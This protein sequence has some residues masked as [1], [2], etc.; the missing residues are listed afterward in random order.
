M[1]YEVFLH[2]LGH[3]Q[4]VDKRARTTRRRFANETRAQEFAEHWRGELWSQRLDHPDPV[5]GPPSP[6]EIKTLGDRWRGSN[7]DY[8]K[9]L[10][11]EK[12][13]RYEEA[14]FLL[15]RAVEWYSDHS[16]AL[17]RLGVLTYAGCGTTQSTIRSIELLGRAVRLDPALFDGNLFLGFALARENRETE[18]RRCF[19]RAILLDKHPPLAMSM[20][21]DTVADWGYFAEAKAL[22]QKAIKRDPKC[23]LAIR[24][25]GRSLVREHNPE[26]D[27]N[28]ER[29][30]ELFERAVAVDP[31][32]AQ[33]HYHL[34]AA[35][36]CIEGE[37]ERAIGHLRKALEIDSTHK[38]AAAALAAIDEKPGGPEES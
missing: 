38:K 11:F 4:V 30:I 25:Y 36:L 19:E 18:A 27:N 14:V 2:E 31:R 8:K 33:S 1:L 24:D 29:A 15:T 10:L 32:K 34:G 26:A 12:A 17:E 22:F 3:I 16:L 23:D 37:N 6:E 9:G 7:S 28:L 35:L 20:Y 13:R 21:A 5:H